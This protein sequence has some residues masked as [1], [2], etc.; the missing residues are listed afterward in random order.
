MRGAQEW[1]SRLVQDRCHAACKN[2][3]KRRASGTSRAIHIVSPEA[4]TAPM[5]R[6]TPKGGVV[7]SAR[8]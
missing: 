5:R 1:M 7:G 2:L 3:S 8:R 6:A 4:R